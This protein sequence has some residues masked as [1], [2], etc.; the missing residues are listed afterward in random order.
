MDESAPDYVSSIVSGLKLGGFTEPSQL[1]QANEAEVI[2]AFPQEEAGK[3]NPAGKAFVR[4]AIAQATHGHLALALPAPPCPPRVDKL[5]DLF[6][7][8]ISAEAVA[9]ALGSRLPPVDVQDL[10]LKAQC[11]GLP[12]AMMLDVSIWQALA[13]DSAA[14]KRT[15]KTMFTYVDFTSKLMLPPWLP[16]DAVS[17]KKRRLEGGSDLDPESSTSSLQALSSALQSATAGPRSLKSLTQRAAIFLRYT[18][19]DG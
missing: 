2:S 10:L 18:P 9:N 8:E 16:A 15:G 1:N 7:L 13:A 14:C 11:S 5:N 6:G 4:R 12:S 3:L 19:R 17:G